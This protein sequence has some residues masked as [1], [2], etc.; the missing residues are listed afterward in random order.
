M[1]ALITGCARFIGSHVAAIDDRSTGGVDGIAHLKKHPRSSY[2][3][4]SYEHSERLCR[5]L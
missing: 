1:N 2:Q 4:D 3:I 5:T